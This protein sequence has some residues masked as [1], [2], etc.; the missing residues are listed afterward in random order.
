MSIKSCDS[1]GMPIEAGPYCQHCVDEKGQLQGF[2]ERFERML[3]WQ[4]RREP[5]A[6]RAELERKTLAYMATMPAWKSHP[7]IKAEFR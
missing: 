3:Q 4:A 2:D 7:R 1:C 5:N 6:S